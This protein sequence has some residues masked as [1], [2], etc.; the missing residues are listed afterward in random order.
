MRAAKWAIVALFGRLPQRDP[1][2][3]GP[4][5]PDEHR[6]VHAR[7]N[8]RSVFNNHGC[9]QSAAYC[10]SRMIVS[11]YRWLFVPVGI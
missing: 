11:V 6:P 1:V 2:V 10:V 3:I 9:G 4:C 5:R 8:T 7:A